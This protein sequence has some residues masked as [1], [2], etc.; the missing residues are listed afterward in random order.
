MFGRRVETIDLVLRK[1]KYHCDLQNGHAVFKWVV[2]NDVRAATSKTR[3]ASEIVLL[4]APA[5][6]YIDTLL[7]Q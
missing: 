6:T 5:P 1:N 7:S 2:R 4:Q 3:R